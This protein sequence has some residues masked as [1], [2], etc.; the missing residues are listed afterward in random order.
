MFPAIFFGKVL[1]KGTTTIE[2]HEDYALHLGGA[3]LVKP[4]KETVSVSV[5]HEGKN[6]VICHLGGDVH[7]TLLNLN[8]CVN[9]EITVTGN[10]KVSLTGF[11]SEIN[12]D[13]EMFGDEDDFDMDEEYTEEEIEALRQ[14]I[15]NKNK[16]NYNEDLL[17]KD[18]QEKYQQNEDDSMELEE[19]GEDDGSLS[20]LGEEAEEEEE[21]EEISKENLKELKKN[22]Q[23]KNKEKFEKNE[24]VQKIEKKKNNNNNKNININNNKKNKKNKNKK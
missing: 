12:D 3:S 15:Q 22:I 18:I 1:E 7:Q 21:E 19:M 16:E 9:T 6:L 11:F 24:V 10:G 23:T 20:P 5:K 2:V 17:L 13:E 8:F 14:K 4:T